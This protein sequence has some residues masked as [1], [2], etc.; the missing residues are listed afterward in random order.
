MWLP[1]SHDMFSSRPYAEARVFAS[2][3]VLNAGKPFR[4]LLDTGATH[5]VIPGEVLDEDWQQ[6][7]DRLVRVRIDCPDTGSAFREMGW[8]GQVEDFYGWSNPPKDRPLFLI[9][10]IID[11]YEIRPRG[12]VI[13][14]MPMAR[15]NRRLL[16]VVL[17]S[18]VLF[19]HHG[20]CIDKTQ[21]RFRL[22]CCPDLPP[23]QGNV[24]VV[25]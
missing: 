4:V 20:L 24:A 9:S 5:C 23:G 17:G 13:M 11:G 10:L 12:V 7:H 14:P 18:D 21:W 3:S 19:R 6:S 8:I 22:N 15:T 2:G 1:L 25:P 16:H